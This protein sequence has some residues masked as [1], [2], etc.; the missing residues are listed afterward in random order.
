MGVLGT[1]DALQ[2]DVG[3]LQ[4]DQRRFDI[5]CEL[6]LLVGYEQQLLVLFQGYSSRFLV[7]S[8]IERFQGQLL[9]LRFGQLGL[10]SPLSPRSCGSLPSLAGNVA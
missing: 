10:S 4:G 6:Q 8:L 1:V 7:S 3:F 2:A 5:L 9:A